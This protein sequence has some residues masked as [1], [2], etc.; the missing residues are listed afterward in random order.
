[1]K[2]LLPEQ[3]VP[4]EFP[5]TGEHGFPMARE[6]LIKNAVKIEQLQTTHFF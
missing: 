5:D 3:E 4:G 6:G 1:M 2:A